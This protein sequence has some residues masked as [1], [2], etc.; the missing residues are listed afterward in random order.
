MEENKIEANNS[1]NFSL[2]GQY[3]KDLSFENPG[4]PQSLLNMKEPPGIEINVDMNAQRL[5]ENI[6]ELAMRISARAIT[7]KS[8]LFVSELVY[9]GI[10]E[11]NN[12]PEDGLERVVLV[13]CAYILFPFARRVIAD[14]TSDGGFPPLQLEPIDFMSLYEQNK[15]N[16]KHGTPTS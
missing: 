3:I 6:F 13:D 7:D 16:I 2:K 12:I 9:G 1:P 4:A 5:Q 15:G 8:T 14:I 10:F 11:L